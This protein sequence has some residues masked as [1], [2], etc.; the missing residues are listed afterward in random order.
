MYFL[1]E[2]NKAKEGN[3]GWTVIIDGAGLLVWPHGVGLWA[4]LSQLGI[5]LKGL[6][7]EPENWRKREKSENNG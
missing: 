1:Q 7:R 3:A 6:E 4:S 2:L 5:D